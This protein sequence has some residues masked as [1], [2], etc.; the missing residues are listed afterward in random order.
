MQVQVLRDGLNLGA[1]MYKS[2]A[3]CLPG[4]QNYFSDMS[5]QNDTRRQAL[6]YLSRRLAIE[7]RHHLGLSIS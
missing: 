6:K 1:S 3:P 7:I 4:Q 2:P 5:A